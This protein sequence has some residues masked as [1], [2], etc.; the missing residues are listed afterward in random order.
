[1]TGF[2]DKTAIVTGAG[3]GLGEA[4]GK[5]LAARGANV[6]VSDINLESVERVA[7]EIEGAGGT[8]SAVRQD[9]AKPEDSKRVV[10]HAVDRFGALHFAVNNA[11]IG[12]AQA[13]TGE[14]DLED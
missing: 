1:M 3:S 11:G 2:A 6:V 4:I 13:P 12:G 7:S 9:T 8:A 14:I 10:R 5:A